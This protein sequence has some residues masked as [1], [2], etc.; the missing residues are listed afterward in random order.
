MVLSHE[1]HLAGNVN[2]LEI[3]LLFSENSLKIFQRVKID[4]KKLKTFKK[5]NI[6]FWDALK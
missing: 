2:I 6:M 1:N 5:I 4:E 3:D